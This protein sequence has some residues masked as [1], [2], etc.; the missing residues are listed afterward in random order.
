MFLLRYLFKDLDFHP[1][2]TFTE[3]AK[4]TGWHFVK[5]LWEE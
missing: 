3:N 2:S 1:E 4:S 5:T